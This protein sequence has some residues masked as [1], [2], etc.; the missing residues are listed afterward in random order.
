MQAE[1]ALREQQDAD[2]NL[3]KE[4][5]LLEQAD[6]GKTCE[7]KQAVAPSIPPSTSV[8]SPTTT[9]PDV[10]PM[11]VD[12]QEHPEAVA[13]LKDA[14]GARVALAVELAETP[15]S[16][17]DIALGKTSTELVTSSRLTMTLTQTDRQNN[18]Y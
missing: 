17:L 2:E 4:L 9:V 11:N 7:T 5:K 1:K 16:M 15:A 14:K 6:K 8:G 18:D 10:T 3:E 13:D 12:S